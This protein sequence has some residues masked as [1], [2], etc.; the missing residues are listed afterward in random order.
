MTVSAWANALSP[1]LNNR[2]EKV[3][4]KKYTRE[5]IPLLEFDPDKTAV[6]EPQ[7]ILSKKGTCLNIA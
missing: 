1:T 3:N 6:I 2:S 5:D 7:P 4:L